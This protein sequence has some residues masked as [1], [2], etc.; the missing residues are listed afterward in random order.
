MCEVSWRLI[1]ENIHQEFKDI[2][3]DVQ[4]ISWVN[5]LMRD[6]YFLWEI[7][8]SDETID[9]AINKGL[10]ALFKSFK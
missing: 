8:V 4:T 7:F 3:K 5:P 1:L 10:N 9:K 2:F 6:N